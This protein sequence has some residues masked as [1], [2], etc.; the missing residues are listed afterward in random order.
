MS[1]V[2]L[3]AAVE[4]EEA[5]RAAGGTLK[6][7]LTAAMR[8]VQGH[9]LATREEDQFNAAFVGTARTCDDEEHT[10]LAAEMERMKTLEAVLSG[11]PV[12]W[13]AVEAQGGSDRPKPLGAMAI[14]LSVRDGS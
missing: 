3:I 2:V 11:V 4:A 6:E 8:A 13:D 10:R 9:W 5:A 12:D 1:N 7:R 14:W